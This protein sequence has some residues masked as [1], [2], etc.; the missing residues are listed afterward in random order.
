M[1]KTRG[2]ERAIERYANPFES[3]G[4]LARVTF[5][6]FAR[7]LEQRI[8]AYGVTI[9][10]WRFLRELWRE[11]GVTQREL[12]ERLDLR[13]PSTVAAV[14]SLEAAGLIRRVPDA[15][16]RR[17]VRIHLTPHAA[18]LRRPLLEHVMEVNRIAT[19]GIPKSD[20]ETARRVFLKMIENLNRVARPDDRLTTDADP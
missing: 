19:R 5:R 13:E 10:Q 1:R 4:H 14:R 9:G 12:S 18:R 6:T 11:D 8:T 2:A 20:L 3:F 15:T 7:T 17:K 16:D